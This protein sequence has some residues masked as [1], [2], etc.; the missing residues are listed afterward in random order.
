MAQEW[1]L[2]VETHDPADLETPG[3]G[4]A[5]LDRKIAAALSN[6]A[7]GELGKQLTIASSVALGEGK[8]ARGRVLLAMVFKYYAAGNNAELI[9]DIDHLQKI[10]SAR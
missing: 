10:T 1:I 4:W 5:S 8:A 2:K 6:I 9:H 3:V 7:H